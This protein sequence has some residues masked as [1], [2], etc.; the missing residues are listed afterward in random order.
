[1]SWRESSQGGNIPFF[2]SLIQKFEFLPV[3]LNKP[4]KIEFFA[5]AALVP[6]P[7]DVKVKK[8]NA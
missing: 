6:K 8:V 4:P 2:T 7:F 1:M 3:D 5:G